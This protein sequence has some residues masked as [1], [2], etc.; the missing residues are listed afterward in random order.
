MQK[1]KEKSKVLISEA[2]QN[3]IFE[4]LG[5]KIFK[6]IIVGTLEAIKNT[7]SNFGRQSDN[8]RTWLVVSLIKDK[9]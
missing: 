4:I 7:E 6:F 2:K 3:H 1:G 9:C 5:S 8:L